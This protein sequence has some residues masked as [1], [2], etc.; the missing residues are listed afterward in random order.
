MALEISRCE[1]DADHEEWR[2][3]RIAV[4]PYERTQSLAELRAGDTPD[5]LLLLARD[6]R[7]SSATACPPG[8]T[9]RDRGVDPAR[10]GRS[11]A[12]R[13]SAR[14]CCGRLIEHVASLD[15]PMLRAGADDEGSLA[16]ARRFGFEEVNREVEQ[17]SASPVR[18]SQAP[19]PPGS[20]W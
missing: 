5:R 19:P 12:G 8:L 18:W 3:V 20:R 13:A 1:T 7:R 4:I 9:A 14:P 17:T 15:L 6:G 10:A 16:F 2:R 11:I